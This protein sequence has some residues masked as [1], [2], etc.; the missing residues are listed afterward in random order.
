M[1]RTNIYLEERQAVALDQVARRQGV[2]RAAVVRRY[3][4]QGLTSEQDDVEGDV[5][6]L[7]ESFGV[8]AHED[9]VAVERSDGERARHLERLWRR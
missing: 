4:D 2:T 6:A 9:G 3:V 1:H 5:A 8:L 7:Q